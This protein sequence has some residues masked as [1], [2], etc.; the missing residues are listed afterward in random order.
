VGE[1]PITSGSNGGG[2]TG[3]GVKLKEICSRE[4]LH[5]VQQKQ[6]RVM[7]GNGEKEEASTRVSLAWRAE[8]HAKRDRAGGWWHP[9]GK[10]G[11]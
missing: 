9:G 10:E 4:D 2:K 6:S 3:I 8:H 11:K 1:Q 5:E 7:R